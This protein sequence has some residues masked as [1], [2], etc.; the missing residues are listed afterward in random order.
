M[1][2]ATNALEKCRIDGLNELFDTCRHT[3]TEQTVNTFMERAMVMGADRLFIETGIEQKDVG[4]NNTRLELDT[5]P[6]FMALR[7]E[8]QGKTP[9]NK[10]A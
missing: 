3:V 8:W 10:T 6:E 7:A 2:T 1:K 4:Y 5:D 9:T